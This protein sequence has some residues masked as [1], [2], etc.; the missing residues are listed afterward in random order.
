MRSDQMLRQNLDLAF[1]TYGD[2]AEKLKAL[3]QELRN[4]G[5]RRSL[6]M[7]I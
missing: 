6:F 3:T 2:T 7:P 4:G 1:R 5:V